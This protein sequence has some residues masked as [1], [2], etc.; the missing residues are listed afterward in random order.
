MANRVGTKSKSVEFRYGSPEN[1]FC[2][3]TKGHT[4]NFRSLRPLTAN[5]NEVK[6]TQ[7]SLYYKCALLEERAK[8]LINPLSNFDIIGHSG[9]AMVKF[10]NRISFLG[11]FGDLNISTSSIVD[12][13]SLTSFRFAA[14]GRS[15]LRFGV[16]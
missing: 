3:T 10:M 12:A 15:D 13:E 9:C 1:L 14:R 8:A 7:L 2:G 6:V 11:R 4:P 5:L 16:L